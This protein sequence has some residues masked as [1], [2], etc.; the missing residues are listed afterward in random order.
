MQSEFLLGVDGGGTHCRARL[1]TADGRVLAE[2]K[3]GAA[4]VYSDFDTALLTLNSLFR[5]ILQLAGLTPAAW[6]K[7][8]A[9][10]GLAGANVPSVSARLHLVPFPFA[11]VTLL[12]DVEIACIGAHNGEP[13]AVLIVGTGSQGVVWDGE[14]FRHIGGWGLVLSDQGSGALLGQRLLR[15]SLQA[16]EGLLPGSGL[17]HNVMNHFNNAPNALLQWSKTATPGD[18]GQFSPWVFNAMQ[19]GDALAEILINESAAEIA[20]MADALIRDSQRPLALMGG[21]AGPIFPW[22]APEMR[23]K[24][25]PARNDALSGALQLARR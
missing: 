14:H 8:S 2:C 20:Q 9:V 7:T 21:L 23:K 4:N 25:V 13:G 16:H 17:S 10:L 3:S 22:L 12:S 1:A 18:W 19:Q 24:I 11:H 15:K 5:H 6:E